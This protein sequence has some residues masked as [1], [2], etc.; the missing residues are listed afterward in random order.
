MKKVAHNSIQTVFVVDDDAAICAGVADL[1]ESTG[2][3]T[4]H[5]SSAEDFLES[6]EPGMPG[7]LVLDVRL[8]G[9]SG[10]ELHAKLTESGAPLPV[11]VMTAHGDMPMVRKAL[12]AGAVE[13]L[14]KP[15]QDEELLQAVKQAFARDREQ[16]RA[17]SLMNSIQACA[18]TLSE[19]EREVM[20]LVAAG[21]TNK[22]IAERLFL[23]V[24]TIKLHR[25][26][27]MRK[28]HAESLADLVRMSEKINPIPKS[29]EG[30]TI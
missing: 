16:R 22:E 11:I 28:M 27:V 19:R 12:K 13:F 2:L 3:K 14:I 26:Q 24:V 15:F 10:M 17:N 4:E 5:F 20:E 1:L 23:S 29:A 7:C 6:W 25:G 18:E 30:G 9:M 8:P 21:L